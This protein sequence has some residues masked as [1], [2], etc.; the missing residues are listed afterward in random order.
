MKAV[1][2]I[3]GTRDLATFIPRSGT[4]D[5]IEAYFDGDWASDDIERKSASCGF[6]KVGGCRLHSYSRT[7]GQHALCSGESEEKS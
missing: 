5:S 6:L 2:Y 7:T 4:A 1:R 3:K